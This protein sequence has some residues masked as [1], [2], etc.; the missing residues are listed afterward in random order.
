MRPTGSATPI[1]LSPA[2]FCRCTP[3]W[4]VRENG[5]RGSSAPGTARVSLQPS[6]SSMRARK[7]STP[8]RSSTYF[9][10]AL[11]R[12]VR[13][14]VSM[15]TRTTASATL[16]ASFGSTSTPVSPAKLKWPVKPPRQSL[17]QTPGARPKPSF[18]ATA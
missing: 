16:V 5:G 1:Q 6:F 15:N 8:S 18:T 13:S 10:L 2:C 17:N 4:A 9:S 12:S 11:V 3:R 7:A 14:P